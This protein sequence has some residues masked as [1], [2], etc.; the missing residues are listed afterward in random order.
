MAYKRPQIAA[1]LSKE[2]RAKL[3][4]EYVQHYTAL[5]TSDIFALNQKMPKET[6]ADLLDKIG[7]ILITE[8]EKLA[9]T[10]GGVQTF[11]QNNP[12]P[13]S[14]GPLLPDS[15]RAFC[16]ALNGL[17]QWVA[18]EQGAMDRYI[19]GNSARELCRNAG[20]K[21]MVTTDPLGSD[22]ELHHPVRDGRPPLRLSKKGHRILEHQE[23]SDGDDPVAK[24]LMP[25]RRENH[26][27]WALLRRGCL[28]LLG[29]PSPATSAGMKSSA[30]THARK[31]ADLS[32]RDYGELLSWLDA[33]G[34][35]QKP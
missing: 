10:P 33:R 13:S 28:D 26:L 9:K 8:S 23:A 12:V 24:V 30:R 17:K 15:V 1:R 29:E 6:L 22:S 5:A 3:L 16:L 32:G 14:I 18:A 11:L 27:S 4:A 7:E 20:V 2:D 34:L 35:G 31:A 21:C 25:F 19:L